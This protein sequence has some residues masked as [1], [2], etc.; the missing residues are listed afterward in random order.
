M[1]SPHQLILLSD[2][3]RLDLAEESFGYSTMLVS[4]S[5]PLGK[6]AIF[7]CNEVTI[8]ELFGYLLAQLLSV[9]T[10]DFF[11]L[12]FDREVEIPGGY[13]A[14]ANHIAILIELLTDPHRMT[15]ENLVLHDRT[16]TARI[17]ALCYFDRFEWPEIFISDGSVVVLDLERIGPIMCIDEF[18]SGSPEIIQKQLHYRQ[19]EYVNAADSDFRQLLCQAERLQVLDELR[20]EFGNLS[21]NS[22]ESLRRGLLLAGHPFSNLL[23]AFFQSAITKR[24]ALYATEMGIRPWP[25]VDWESAIKCAH[26]CY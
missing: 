12:W 11:G 17:L 13:R 7:K 21:D 22:S 14:P 1:N 4:P 2:L 25:A 6:K 23:S 19:D 18:T 20:A 9:P 8:C 5:N 3:D 16:L 15:L 24:Q 10:P 26:Y